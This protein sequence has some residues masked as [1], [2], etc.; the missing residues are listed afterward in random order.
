VNTRSIEIE[1]QLIERAVERRNALISEAE[2][3][4]QIII[5]TAEEEVERIEAES[6]KQILSL[7][8][9]ELR[10]VND[11]IIGR[12]QLEGRK[13][14]MQSR[15]D[16]L[17]EVF[18]RAEKRLREISGEGADYDAILIRLIVEAASAIG[19]ENFVVAANEQDLEYL[20][21]SV[22]K[23]NSELKKALGEGTVKLDDDPLDVMGGV[24]VKNIEGTKTHY[25][26]LEGRLATARSKIE[27]EVAK[28]IELI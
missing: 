22:R 14:L 20:K 12:A 27:A 10:A 21:K 26:T 18:E 3:K 11:R 5:K 24:I 8:G 25:N 17:T 19:G 13:M 6:E 9:S 2:R 16:M 4:A 23:I 28:K 15:Q 1:A 7:V